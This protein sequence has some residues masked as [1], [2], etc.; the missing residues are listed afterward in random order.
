[1]KIFMQIAQREQMNLKRSRVHGF[2]MNGIL[3][4]PAHNLGCSFV[5]AI[6]INL[7]FRQNPHQQWDLHHSHALNAFRAGP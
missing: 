6:T 5:C 3:F 7:P 1:M 2:V 4:V